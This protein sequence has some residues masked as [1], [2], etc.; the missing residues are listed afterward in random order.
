MRR[1]E[2]IAGM[3][4]SVAWPFAA[5]AQQAGRTH[6]LGWLLPLT[7]DAPVNVAFFDE[8]RRRGFIEGQ[9]L[10]VEYR[11]WALHFD[12][13]SQYAAELVKARVDVI[14]TGGEETLR[15]A[16][17]AT[18]TIPILALAE[19]LLGSGFVNSM[20]R[21]NGNTTGVSI[22]ANVLDGKRQ[23]ILIEAVPGLRRMA[24]LADS[25]TTTVAK[26][27]ALQTAAGARNIEL[28]IHQVARGEEIAAAVDMAKVSGSTALN[29]LASPLLYANRQLII[30]CA[31]ALRLP[32]IYE[33][34]E[35]A[36]EGGFVAYGSRLSEL[37]LEV[38][39]RQLVELLR[40]VKVADIPVEQPTKFELVINL[41]TAN[42]MGV[43]VPATLVARADKVIE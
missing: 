38:M 26:L 22:L 7:R 2:F 11:P 13:V 10:T 20:A 37:F 30:E 12:L 24:T 43:T 1:R 6:R 29:V 40:G 39:P 4:A 9:N 35:T 28:S 3:G 14:I 18:K 32:A 36:E 27:D 25:N 21:P 5:L 23:E 42:A 41:K 17:E 31:A 16:Q 8:L 15:A 34:P 33:F 19:D